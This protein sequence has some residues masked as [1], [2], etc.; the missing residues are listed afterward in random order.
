[1]HAYVV[2]SLLTGARTEELRALTWDHVNLHGEP[3]AVP[4]VPP[5]VAVWRS[6]RAGGDTKTR[7]SRRTLALPQR[8]LEALTELRTGRRSNATRPVSAGTNL[9]W[10]S[11]L[12][13]AALCGPTMCAATSGGRSRAQSG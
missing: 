4:P 7:K 2:V 1:M 8:W 6:V 10:C 11:P 12:G 13:T 9:A 3:D 5:H